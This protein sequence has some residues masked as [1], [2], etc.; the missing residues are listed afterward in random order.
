MIVVSV[1]A[2][3]FGGIRPVDWRHVRLNQTLIV[4]AIA[5]Q[6]V[7]HHPTISHQVDSFSFN[8]SVVFRVDVVVEKG[9]RWAAHVERDVQRVDVVEEADVVIQLL[10]YFELKLVHLVV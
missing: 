8:Q 6:E 2:G 5:S 3:D 4:R 7:D 9:L 10:L 1:V